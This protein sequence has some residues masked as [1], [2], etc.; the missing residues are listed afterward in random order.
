MHE[1]TT[2]I[3][4]PSGTGKELVATSIGLSRY[5]PFDSKR[6]RFVQKFN[7]AFHPINLSAMPKDLE[8]T[9]DREM[10]R[11]PPGIRMARNFSRAGTVRAERHDP[12]R[13]PS[14]NAI[15]SIGRI[16]CSASDSAEHWNQSDN[17][18]IP[19]GGPTRRFDL[20]RAARTLLL[21]YLFS[22]RQSD[23]RRSTSG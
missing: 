16:A 21:G 5:I 13:V 8:S 15:L 10:P 19:R 17:R 20:R 12:R 22:I 1:I 11:A 18:E 7:G 3:L 2:L 9:L 14:A 6:E 23:R 4:G